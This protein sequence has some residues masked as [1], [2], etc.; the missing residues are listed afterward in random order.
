MHSLLVFLGLH[1][2]NLYAQ[3]MGKVVGVVRKILNLIHLRSMC[4]ILIDLRQVETVIYA[5]VWEIMRVA[6]I[7]AREYKMDLNVPV[8]FLEI[9]TIKLHMQ[10]LVI[11]IILEKR[12]AW[13][14][15]SADVKTIAIIVSSQILGLMETELRKPPI[16]AIWK[17]GS[18]Q[19]RYGIRLL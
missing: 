4:G 12:R 8:Q 15:R 3:A 11:R 14:G 17:M 19:K 13:A 6:K 1:T 9:L 2:V 18:G 16:Y 10:L 7:F 5:G